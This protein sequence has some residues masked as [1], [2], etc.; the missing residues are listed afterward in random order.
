METLYYKNSIDIAENGCIIQL[1]SFIIQLFE[2][3]GN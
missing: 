2:K 1:H 3:E